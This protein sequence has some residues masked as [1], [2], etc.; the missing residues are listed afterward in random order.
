M[1]NN[2]ALNWTTLYRLE[3]RFFLIC[4]LALL[5]C[6]N[7]FS[8][9]ETSILSPKKMKKDLSFLIENIEG[10]PDPYTKISEADFS[11]LVK[12]VEKNIST[13]MDEID[14]YKNLAS[15]IASIGDGHSRVS[16][17]RKWISKLKKDHGVFP[18]EVYLNDKE[19]LHVIKSL[20]GDQQLP[21]KA[22]ILE[23]DGMP[24]SD[25]IKEVTPYISYETLPFRNDQITEAFE[26]ML[27]LIFKKADQ[28]RFTYK[29]QE[30]SEAIVST[31][32]YSEWRDVRYDLEEIRDEKIEK[33]Q[34]YD[35]EIIQPGVAKI[36]I[37][38]FA[39]RDIPSYTRFLNK[40]FKTIKEENVHS[41]IIDIRENYG[42]W[43]KVSSKLFHYIYDGYFKT[44]AKSRMKVSN[45]FKRAYLDRFPQ[46]KNAHF[47]VPQRR[48][49]LDLER[50]LNDK[51]GTYVDEEAFF[52][53]SPVTEK[54]EF[55]GD[56]YLLI[57]RK[58]YSASSSFASTFQCYSMGHIIGEPTGGTKIFRANAFHKLFPKTPFILSISSTQLHTTCYNGEDEPVMPDVEVVPTT[59]DRVHESDPQLNMAILLIRKMQRKKA[60]QEAA[61]KK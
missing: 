31:M 46:Y 50:V 60:E 9:V 11:K 12:E 1:L 43:P 58:S 4:L 52:N 14:F 21:L 7:G 41:L 20:N 27:Y 59:L 16:F 51:A 54:F 6:A 36:D 34:P 56:C 47:V 15:L 35:F 2:D 19:E 24:V 48:H 23:I 44:M 26:L 18:Y 8:Q 57:D 22:Q 32:P 37:F 61:Q 17:N 28:L 39:V 38:S 53:E 45:S 10:H 42:G 40:T 25:F 3:K 55:T 30:V 29:Y 49:Y 5:F 13:E 33:G